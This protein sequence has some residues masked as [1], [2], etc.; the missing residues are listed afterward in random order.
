MDTTDDRKDDFDPTWEDFEM[1]QKSAKDQHS[2]LVGEYTKSS[3]RRSMAP[4]AEECTVE[5]LHEFGKMSCIQ[6]LLKTK[7]IHTIAS[8]PKG[9]SFALST[10][11]RLDL[12]HH[13]S[14]RWH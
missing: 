1:W 14:L 10:C 11:F 5:H 13:V 7:D 9:F 2:A 6:E 8:E 3:H 4:I 12:T